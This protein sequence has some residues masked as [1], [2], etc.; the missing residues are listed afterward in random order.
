MSWQLRRVRRWAR[1]SGSVAPTLPTTNLVLFHRSDTGVSLTGSNV[2]T[3][4]DQ[5]GNALHLSKGAASAAIYVANQLPSGK[6]IIRASNSPYTW[7]A[8]TWP[9]ANGWEWHFLMKHNTFVTQN[10]IAV[11]RNAAANAN[12]IIFINGGGGYMQA[13]GSSIIGEQYGGTPGT[14]NYHHLM[15]NWDGDNTNASHFNAQLDTVAL[16]GAGDP[17]DVSGAAGVLW[18]Y[19]NVN[20]TLFQERGDYGLVVLYDRPSSA[21]QLT[22]I[23]TFFDYYAN[24]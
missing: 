17:G 14:S 21:S 10:W 2:D 4:N 8:T 24:G 16:T 18:S 23:N 22:S 20:D 7:P 12:A 1:T 6:G 11:T 5:S 13:N 9:R 19:S 3:W 15:V